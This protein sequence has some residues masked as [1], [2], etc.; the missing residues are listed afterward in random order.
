MAVP[1]F[2]STFEAHKSDRSMSEGVFGVQRIRTGDVVDLRSS[3]F[4]QDEDAE[5]AFCVFVHLAA[6]R[7]HGLHRNSI[8]DLKD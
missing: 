6:D 5:S 8:S 3:G 1:A 7:R 4:W 2:L